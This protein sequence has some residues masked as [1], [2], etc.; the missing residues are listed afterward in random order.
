M[1]DE[2]ELGEL[3]FFKVEKR[4]RAPRE[5]KSLCKG[6]VSRKDHAFRV[7]GVPLRLSDQEKYAAH[8]EGYQ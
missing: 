1:E 6:E 2:L 7:A 3:H 8:R 4:S 5:E